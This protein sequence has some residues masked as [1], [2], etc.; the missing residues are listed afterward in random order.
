MLS[1][2]MAHQMATNYMILDG[3]KN[4]ETLKVMRPYQVYATQKVVEGIKRTDFE[5]GNNKIGYIWHT[6][7]SGKTITSFKTAWLASRMPNVDKVVFVVDRIALT[8]QTSE[9][10]KAYDPDG[11]IGDETR[12]GS[13]RDTNNTN[14][15][16]RKLKS[17]DNNIIVTSVQKLG[18]LVSRKLLSSPHG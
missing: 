6:T 9:D 13:V 18:T 10:Y 7:G 14:D 4:K 5:A 12:L 8:R 15:L 17:K 1:I 2:P 3:T 16:S 11:E